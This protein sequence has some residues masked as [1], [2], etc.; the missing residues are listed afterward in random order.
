MKFKDIFKNVEDYEKVKGLISDL[1]GFEK[2]FEGKELSMVPYSRFKD[3]NDQMNETKK[4]NSEL[5]TKLEKLSK[6]AITPQMLE[7][8]TKALIEEHN[9]KMAEVELKYSN[10]KKEYAIKDALAGAGAKY[11]DLLIHKLDMNKISEKDGKFEGIDEQVKALKENYKDM[12]GVV[13]DVDTKDDGINIYQGIKSAPINENGGSIT[14]VFKDAM[15][16]GNPPS[17]N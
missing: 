11:S 8:K 9:S 7:E 5:N 13:S 14:D 16:G 4:N 1:E 17:A 3:V 15:W 10:L 6:E 2:E 12:F